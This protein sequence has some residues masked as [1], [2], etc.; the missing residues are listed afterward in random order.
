MSLSF[1]E[2][3]DREGKLVYKTRGCS[4]QP[5]LYQDRDI[6][7]IEKSKARLKKYDVAFYKVGEKYILHRVIHVRN[8]YYIMRGDNNLF[9]EKVPDEAVL[10]VLT[11][12][13][14]NG[15]KRSVTD[16]DYIAYYKKRVR[17]YPLR[18]IYRKTRGFA[19]KVKRRLLG[20]SKA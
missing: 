6:V 10:G 17:L 4:M 18:F 15:E 13:V 9:N 12:F 14:Q 8:G 20:K 7:I 16:G 2:I 11:A 3:L 1:E 19:G 5:M